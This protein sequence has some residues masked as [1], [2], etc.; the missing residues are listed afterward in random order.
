MTEIIDMIMELG[1]DETIETNNNEWLNKRW[2]KL[3]VQLTDT[4]EQLY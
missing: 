1:K 4:P 3:L 2:V